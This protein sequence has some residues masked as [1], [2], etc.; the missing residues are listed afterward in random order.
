V[1]S[2][3]PDT[4]GFDSCWAAAEISLIERTLWS[5]SVTDVLSRQLLGWCPG[6]AGGPNMRSMRCLTC[7][8]VSL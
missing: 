7:I 1:K 3:C 4:V 5:V 2:K 6:W 8:G